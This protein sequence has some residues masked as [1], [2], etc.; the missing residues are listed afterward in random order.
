MLTADKFCDI[1]QQELTT[2]FLVVVE[3]LLPSVLVMLP[4]R[5]FI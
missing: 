4:L 5:I 1:S 2:T 3:V